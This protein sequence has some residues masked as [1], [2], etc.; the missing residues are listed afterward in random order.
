MNDDIFFGRLLLIAF[1]IIFPF[2][3][4][5][6]LQSDSGEKL[7]RLKE[8]LF[9]LISLRLV[10][11][12]GII[13]LF[14][15]IINPDNM[16][17]SSLNFST[18]FR[19]FGICLGV[20]AGSLLLY[21]FKTL[22]KNLTDTVVTRKEHLLVTNGPYKFVRHP[23]YV[24]AFLASTANSITAANWFLFLTT[25]MFIFLIILRTKKEEFFLEERFGE[26]YKI[27]QKNTGKFFPKIF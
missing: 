27:Y 5:Y 18:S 24:S 4:Y 25:A 19:W 14:A 10:G 3:F 21:T 23:F 17:W 22:G 1:L 7:D 8:G 16:K 20:F 12:V 6:R 11:F 26:N 13:A 2:A 15:F 9:I